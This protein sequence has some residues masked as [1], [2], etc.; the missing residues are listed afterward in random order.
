[1]LIDAFSE[2]TEEELGASL[3]LEDELGAKLGAAL[4]VCRFPVGVGAAGAGAPNSLGAALK[5]FCDG[6]SPKELS[7]T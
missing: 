4:K 1:M 7:V 6:A 2:G 3:G 5:E